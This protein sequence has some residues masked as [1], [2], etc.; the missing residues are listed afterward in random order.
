MADDTFTDAT[1]SGGG[2]AIIRVSSE[3]FRTEPKPRMPPVQD[4]VRRAIRNL[5]ERVRE[6]LDL[7]S[8]SEVIE[9]SNRLEA[10]SHKIDAL[11]TLGFHLVDVAVVFRHRLEALAG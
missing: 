5:L 9:L 11:E 4:T 2:V 8:R 10:I 6:E 1:E 3:P 7:P